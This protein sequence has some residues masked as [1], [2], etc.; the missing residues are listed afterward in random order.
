M[1]Q[2]DATQECLKKGQVIAALCL[3]YSLIDVTASLERL[4]GEGTRSAFVRWVDEHM[5]KGRSLPYSA[6]DLYGARCGVLHTFT[7]D[8]DLCREG[9]ARKIVY[10][11]GS[12]PAEDLADTARIIGRDEIVIHIEELLHSFRRGLEAYLDGVIHD[13]ERLRKTEAHAELWFTS[14]D[15][16]VVDEFL[17]IF[18]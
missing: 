18:R 10:A 12:A 14:L 7:P 4:S 3:L 5:L 13:P 6:L 17:R 11:W 2:L 1:Q 16:Q 15:R 8:S 9:K